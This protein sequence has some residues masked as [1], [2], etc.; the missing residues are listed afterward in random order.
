MPVLSGTTFL[1]LHIFKIYYRRSDFGSHYAVL[2]EILKNMVSQASALF[3]KDVPPAKASVRA[4]AV[5]K[6]SSKR[7]VSEPQQSRY[8]HPIRKSSDYDGLEL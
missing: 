2:P 3:T 8:S 6:N 5:R 1:V 4:L 7:V